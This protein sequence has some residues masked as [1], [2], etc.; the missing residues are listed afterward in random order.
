MNMRLLR[1]VLCVLAALAVLV[2]AGC[3]GGS[4]SVPKD[5]VAVVGDDT[6]TKAEFN[7]LIAGARS[8]AKA[9]K[10]TFP[11]PGTTE[12]KTLQDKAMAY[13][14][15]EKELEQAGKGEGVEVTNA[16]V[17]K[18]IADIK[19]RVFGGNEQAFQTQ[20]KQQGFTLPLLKVFQKGNLL[21]DKLYKKVTADVKVSD[22]DIKKYYN[23]NAATQ[24]TTL[25]SRDV[26]HILVSSKAKADALEAQLK[27]GADFAKLAKK[28]STD[29]LSAVKGGKLTVEKGKTVPEFDKAAFSLKT[30]EISPPVHS[31]YG[32]HIIQA[33]GPIKPEAKK[34]LS[35]VKGEI[36]TNLLQTKK[37]EAFQKWLDDLRKDYAK[38]VS[39]QTGY[40]PA[41]TASLPA[42]TTSPST[43]TG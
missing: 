19:K 15:Q 20:L 34:P 6:I 36:R 29:T 1:S 40:A 35:Q 25:A 38:K 9:A 33:L 27:S 32:W 26:R 30:N 31:Q 12:Y 11:R 24:F 8:Q 17:D 39:Y 18:Q 10:A 3:G 14:V 22:A 42:T 21:S 28:N 37:Q 7:F 4:K 23:E 43:S 41:S 5:A 2:A 16:D 13:L